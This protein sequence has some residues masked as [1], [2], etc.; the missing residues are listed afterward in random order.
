MVE[1]SVCVFVVIFKHNLH[2]FSANVMPVTHQI[3]L[4]TSLALE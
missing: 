3:F 4:I 2:L 1:K